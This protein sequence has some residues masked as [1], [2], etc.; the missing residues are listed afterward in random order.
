LEENA[1]AVEIKLTKEELDEI[2]K[3]VES[4]EVHGERYVPTFLLR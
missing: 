3:L 1:A 2:R 4:A